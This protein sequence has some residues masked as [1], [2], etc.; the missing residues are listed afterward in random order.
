MDKVVAVGVI[1]T[2]EPNSIGYNGDS[3]SETS[4]YGPIA[5]Q[6]VSTTSSLTCPNVKSGMS[7]QEKAAP[8]ALFLTEESSRGGRLRRCVKSPPESFSS[9]FLSAD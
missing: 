4:G 2:T 3:S 1:T 6:S 5:S 9:V 7:A 8:A